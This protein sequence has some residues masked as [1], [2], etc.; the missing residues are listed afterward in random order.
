MGCCVPNSNGGNARRP[1]P[2]SFV[3]CS[4]GETEAAGCA[5]GRRLRP[6]D[7]VCLLGE[8][9]AGKTRFVSGAM[10]A[11]GAKAPVLSPTFILARETRIRRTGRAAVHMDF[12]RLKVP[13]EQRGLMDYLDGNR[14]VFIEW[15]DRDRSFWPPE[16]IVVR[17]DRLPGTRRRIKITMPAGRGAGK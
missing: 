17:I 7:C 8:L 16:P 5:L 1:E 6:G 13:A 12:Y 10:R 4:P 3:S 14:I 2:V 15:A 11:L 9:G